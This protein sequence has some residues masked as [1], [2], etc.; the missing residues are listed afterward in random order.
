MNTIDDLRARCRIDE[1]TRCWIW[2]GA[3]SCDCGLPRIHGIDYARKTKRVM[4]GPTA[5]WNIAHEAAPPPGHKVYRTCGNKLCLNPVHL[6]LART[7]A[8]L[9]RLVAQSNR[10]KGT[11]VEQRR[12]AA[13]KG[14]AAQGIRTTPPDVVA[15]ILRADG[16]N[17]Q[18]AR[19]LGV[20]H[21]VVSRVRLRQVHKE[22]Q[23]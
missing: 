22:I 17:C 9:M 10:L 3:V 7:Q 16:N 14:H 6:R 4:S 13:R 19:R 2:L 23:P 1:A 5:A 15:Q 18:V 11:H 8:D 12:A 20:H 21:S